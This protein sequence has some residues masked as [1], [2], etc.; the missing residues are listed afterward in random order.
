VYEKSFPLQ[1]QIQGRL[2]EIKFIWNEFK[3]R[4]AGTLACNASSQGYLRREYSVDIC[5]IYDPASV[6]GG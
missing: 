6:L 2:L 1:T 4:M 5:V 3:K